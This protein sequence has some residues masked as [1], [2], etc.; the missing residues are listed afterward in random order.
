MTTLTFSHN[1]LITDLAQLDDALRDQLAAAGQRY[2]GVAS[3]AADR[4]AP[5][6]FDEEPDEGGP[7]YEPE[8]W[9]VCDAG[10]A[11]LYQLWLYNADSGTLFKHGTTEVVAEIIQFGLETRDE[12][13]GELLHDAKQRAQDASGKAPGALRSVDFT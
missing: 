2:D 6:G 5:E 3:P 8:V 4:I 1:R 13:L 7:L 10:G 11:V 9:D 12:Q